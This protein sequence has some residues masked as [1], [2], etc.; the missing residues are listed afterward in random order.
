MKHA[1]IRWAGQ[2]ALAVVLFALAV[3]LAGAQGWNVRLVG[4]IGGACYAVAVQGNYAYIGE[5]PNLTI[6]NVSTPARPVVV[7]KIRLPYIVQGIAVS[8]GMAYVADGDSGLQIVSV[9]NPAS[10][11]LRGSYDTPGYAQG[12]AVSGGMAYVADNEAGLQI[13]DVS[14]P[15]SPQFRGSYDTPGSGV[16]VAVSGGMAFVADG[17]GGLQIIDV[18]IPSW[19]ELRG[20]YDTPGYAMG[21]AVAGGLAYVA[22]AYSGL[23]IIDVSDPSWPQL[24]GSYGALGNANGV[25]VSGG[26]AY[27]AEG[28]DYGFRGLQIIDVRNPSSPQLRGAYDTPG[29]ASHV[30]VSGGLAYVADGSRWN[31]AT[32][33]GGLQIISVSNP[34]WPTLRGSYDTPGEACDVAVSGGLAF[35]ADSTLGPIPGIPSTTFD[36]ISRWNGLQIIDVS[37][38]SSPQFRGSYATPGY[39]YGVAVSGGLAYV[40]DWHGGLWILQYT[41]P[42]PRPVAPLNLT[43]TA[44]STSR[45][46]LSWRDNSNNEQGFRIQRK[47]GVSGAWS[48]IATVG[49]NVRTYQN[50]GLSRNTTYYYRV[51]AYNAAGNSVWSNEASARTMATAARPSWSLYR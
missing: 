40:A 9:S 46:A 8:G 44:L 21:V 16:G 20:S 31:G 34:W 25:V 12:V 23:Q 51:C 22:D 11:Q 37:N 29:E 10:P 49:A 33:V 18:S 24:R 43:A 45:I 15:S 19:P 48:Q 39:A 32:Y 4:Q 2:I 42:A 13:I 27:V 35:V 5:G 1:A 7:G 17:Y 6:L 28:S 38:P 30:A 36:S 41:G 14:N 26:M 3:E 50:T 47:T